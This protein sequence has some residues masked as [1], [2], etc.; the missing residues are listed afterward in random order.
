[1]YVNKNRVQCMY[2]AMKTCRYT[3]MTRLLYDYNSYDNLI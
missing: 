3:C 1:M 2:N